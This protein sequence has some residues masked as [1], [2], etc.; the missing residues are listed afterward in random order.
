MTSDAPKND[1]LFLHYVMGMMHGGM[2]HL[3]KIMNPATQ[4]I[5][6]D[7]DAVRSIIDLLVMLREKTQGNL[8]ENETNALKTAIS[9]LQLNYIDE[10]KSPDA[11]SPATPSSSS[12]DEENTSTSSSE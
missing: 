2:V 1:E 6:K 12:A 10:A 9:T 11:S 8:N 7:L 3:G 4:K 5:E